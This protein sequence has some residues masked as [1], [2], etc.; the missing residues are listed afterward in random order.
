MKILGR[1]I[2]YANHF[3]EIMAAD[4]NELDLSEREQRWLRQELVHLA[5][6]EPG[7]NCIEVSLQLS[8]WMQAGGAAVLFRCMLAAKNF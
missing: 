8:R 1:R 6:V 4:Y 5:A 2:G 7:I 3:N